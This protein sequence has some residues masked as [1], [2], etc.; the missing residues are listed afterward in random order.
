M[1]AFK[2]FLFWL[3]ARVE[4]SNDTDVLFDELTNQQHPRA[5]NVLLVALNLSVETSHA[6]KVTKVAECLKH[7][8]LDI[9]AFKSIAFT[10]FSE[11]LPVF[12]EGFLV[13]ADFHAD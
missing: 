5:R 11:K 4:C 2:R 12:M 3:T 8:L 9:G 13:P 6:R 7:A 1:A 10:C